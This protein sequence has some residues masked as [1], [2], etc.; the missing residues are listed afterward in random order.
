MSSSKETKKSRDILCVVTSD[1]MAKSR[2]GTV[3]RLV[4]E[5]TYKKYIRRTTKLMFHDETNE[6]KLGDKVLISSSRPLSA[7]KRFTLV[8]VVQKAGEKLD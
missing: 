4:K 2:V 7:K 8:K 5:P 1:K 6:S 3:E